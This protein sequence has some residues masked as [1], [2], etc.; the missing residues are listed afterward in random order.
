MNKT[1]Q[2]VT[3]KD[4]RRRFRSSPTKNLFSTDETIAFTAELYNQTFQLVND[5]EAFLVVRD[6]DGNEYSYTFTRAE[7]TYVL[8]I[9]R[10]AEGEYSYTA[11]TDYEGQR[12]QVAGR[13]NVQQIML[14]SYITQADHGLLYAMTEKFGGRVFYPSDMSAIA[15]VI[16]TQEPKPVIY[17]SGRNS[18]LLNIQWLFAILMFILGL[19]W[20]LRRYHGAY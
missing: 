12:Q 19:E 3:V 17:Q 7:N 9:G 20:F 11:F 4:D 6:A 16:A 2:Y 1:V 13:F 14:E 8:D 15:D 5:P 10:F 18:P